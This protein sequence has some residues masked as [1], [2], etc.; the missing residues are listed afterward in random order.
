MAA[1][2]AKK[3]AKKKVAKRAPAKAA[4]VKTV[5]P[6]KRAKSTAKPAAK[7]A[8]PLQL[9]RLPRRKSTSK[10]VAFSPAFAAQRDAA[11]H[12]D[13][14]LFE[15]QRARVAVNAALQGMPGG[16]AER[17]VRPGG[18]TIRQV[19][20]HLAVRDRAR[21]AEF[22]S[23]L[24]GTP[25]SWAG[26]DDVAMAALN[27][28]Q[29]QPYHDFSWDM[30]VRLLHI[31]RAQL[32]DRLVAVPHGPAELWTEQHAFGAMLWMLPAHDRHHA[33]QLKNARIRG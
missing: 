10:V 4:A 18:W 13:L 33:D 14:L 23:A 12:K 7:A 5:A 30:A 3:T 21:L 29:L 15:L 25:A 19:V 22:E 31:N 6:K 20:L 11:S 24:A 8:A 28:M 9:P 32:L 16:A 17:E 27:E 26:L 1:R 2:G